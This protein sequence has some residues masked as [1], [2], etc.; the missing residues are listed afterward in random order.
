MKFKI[1]ILILIVPLLNFGQ[2]LKGIVSDSISK[3]KLELVNITFL[4]SS[5]GTNTNLEGNYF[6]NIKG[7]LNDS[8][9]VSYI[10]YKP[11][12]ISLKKFTENNEYT[13]NFNLEPEVIIIEEV[14]ITQKNKKYDKKYILSEK[15]KGDVAM[16]SIIGY[17]TTCLI[18]NPKNEIGRI[19]SI[20]LYIRKNKEADFIAKFRIKIYSY[21]KVENI[22]GENILNEDLIIS[23]KNKN[24]QYTIDLENKKLPFLEDG[25]CVGIEMVDENNISKK[26]DKVGPGIRFTY[27]EN[28]QLTWYNYRN[29][30][31]GENKIQNKKSFDISNLMVTMAVLMKD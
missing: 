1:V 28:K 21:N 2:S 30:T 24:Y 13:L 27:G 12:F 18:E 23:P 9:K 6:L 10:G 26:T 16:F 22:P 7:H 3:Q 29:R 8:I 19:K 5:N 15:R 25:V 20:K 31:W 4:K 17:E 11:K 14:I